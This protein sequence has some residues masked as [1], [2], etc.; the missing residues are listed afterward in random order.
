MA[1]NAYERET[2]IRWSED[3]DDPKAYIYTASKSMIT[4]LRKNPAVSEVCS[5]K[6]EGT[7]WAEFEL[8]EAALVSIRTKRRT[9]SM[10]E[11]QRAAAGARLALARKAG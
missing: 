6:H 7:A 8:E 4:S 2:I 1:L 10:T 5:G 11:A 9:S 3:P